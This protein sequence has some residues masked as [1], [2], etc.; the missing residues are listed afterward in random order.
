MKTG[1]NMVTTC[2]ACRAFLLCIAGAVCHKQEEHM[3]RLETLQAKRKQLDAQIQAVRSREARNIRARDTRRKVVLG[4]SI[5]RLVEEGKLG[6]DVLDSAKG[7][8]SARDRA[9]FDEW[10]PGGDWTPNDKTLK[11][12]Q[13]SRDGK[14]T[15]VTIEELKAIAE[16]EQHEA[17]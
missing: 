7:V 5:L 16:A 6:K 17:A 12:I 13:E 15:P 14:T 11:A 9:M 3:S 10:I 1:Y 4:G 2:A 8:M